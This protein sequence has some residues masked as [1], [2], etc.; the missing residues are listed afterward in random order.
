MMYV[1][2]FFFVF[3]LF[4][5]FLPKQ[6]NKT[7]QNILLENFKNWLKKK[8]KSMSLGHSYGEVVLLGH[9]VEFPELFPDEA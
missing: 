5:A 2:F 6:N 1:I 8:V 3:S 7:K 9:G 4:A